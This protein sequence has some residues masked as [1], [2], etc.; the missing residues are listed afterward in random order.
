LL[1]VRGERKSKHHEGNTHGEAHDHSG[2]E[3]L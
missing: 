2:N 3:Q 1:K